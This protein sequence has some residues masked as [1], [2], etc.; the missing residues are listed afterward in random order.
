MPIPIKDGTILSNDWST[1]ERGE[2]RAAWELMLLRFVNTFLGFARD[3]GVVPVGFLNIH[4]ISQQNA[5]DFLLRIR[6]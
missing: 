2:T 6:L 5:W 3:S 1:R 4:V